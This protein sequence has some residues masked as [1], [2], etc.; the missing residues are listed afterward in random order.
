MLT[1][2]YRLRKVFGYNF[3]DDLNYE[4][5]GAFKLRFESI[6]GDPDIELMF[7][8]IV[9]GDDSTENKDFNDKEVTDLIFVYGSLPSIE[10]IIFFTD[11][12]GEHR[13]GKSQSYNIDPAHKISLTDTKLIGMQATFD[14]VSTINNYPTDAIKSLGTI[15]D[16]ITTC[17]DATFTGELTSVFIYD[18]GPGDPVDFF[19]DKELIQP[20]SS[21]CGFTWTYTPIE[22]EWLEDVMYQQG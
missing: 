19:H 8:S 20:D 1:K 12:G 3:K 16:Q 10:G 13:I 18:L 15:V 2:D 9:G 4:R 6:N 22:P 7:G 14:S 5:F 21:M 11:D 17:E